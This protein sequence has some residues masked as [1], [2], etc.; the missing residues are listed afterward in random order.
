MRN[1]KIGSLV[2]KHL[3]AVHEIFSKKGKKPSLDEYLNLLK[4][5]VSKDLKSNVDISEIKNILKN[6]KKMKKSGVDEFI[7]ADGSYI[8]GDWN[9]SKREIFVGKD[10]P[11]TSS[12][13]SMF[14]AQGPRYYYTPHYGASR[15]YT[16]ES[17]ANNK[18][19]SMIE[20]IIGKNYLD[21]DVIDKQN[22]DYET[23]EIP[24]LQHLKIDHQRPIIARKTK[25][26]GEMME[27]EGVTGEEMAIVVNHLLS[28]VDISTIPNNYKK[29]IINKL[30]NGKF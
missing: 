24:N 12:E 6:L 9:P 5:K 17:V 19:K 4:E 1:K 8:S 25:Y 21:N 30:R 13:F 27:R 3:P 29:I 28:L 26:L 22:N 18:M 15:V 11:E 2:H 16:R 23:E 10:R 14:T 7:D 20:D